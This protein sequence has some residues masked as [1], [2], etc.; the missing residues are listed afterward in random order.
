MRRRIL[1]VDDEVAVL[2]TLKAV[3]EISGF[4]VDTAA[5]AREGIS[6]LHTR[7]YQMLITDMRMEHDVAGIEVIKAARLANYHPA[8][9]LLTAFP[10]A[11]EDWQEMGADQLLVKPMHTR[12]LL[13][14]I[15][16]LIA[17][18]ERKLA[19]LGLT[20]TASNPAA[21][22]ATGKKKTTVKKAV[23]KKA[24]GKKAVVKKAIA[25]KVATRTSP[26]KKAATA[27]TPI[28]K[29]SVV[30]K[31]IVKKAIAKKATKAAAKSKPA[32]RRTKS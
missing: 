9:A 27:K 19:A 3:L 17:S 26:A 14:Q 25:K 8:V 30:K 23:G 1:L 28:R 31:A 22:K 21:A 5:S 32:R 20:L 7:E 13:Q 15:E 11:E 18:H 24:V 2:L 12:I 29:K 4:D 6:K 16:D 10:V